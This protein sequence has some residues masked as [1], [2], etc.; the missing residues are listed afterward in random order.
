MIGASAWVDLAGLPRASFDGLFASGQDV[1]IAGAFAPGGSIR[2]VD[3]G[4]RV[5]GRW[6]FV[7]GCEHATWLY[8]N[9]VEGVENG[10]PL[11]RTAV[12]APDEVEIEDTW[13]VAGLCGP[14]AITSGR[15]CVVPAERTLRP[16]TDE[17]CLDEPIV[18][19][20]V[21]RCGAVVASVALG[22][23][24]GHWTT[25]S[26]SQ[27]IGRRS[28]RGTGGG[29]S[30]VP[31]RIGDGGHRAPGCPRGAARVGGVAV[32]DGDAGARSPCDSAPTLAQLRYGDRPAVAVVQAA[33]RSAGGTAVYRT[34]ALQR[35]LRD[36]FAVTQ[37][38]IVRPDAMATAGAVLVGHDITVPIF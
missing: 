16:L 29:R 33:Y 36:V 21:P 5:T 24:Q 3:G 25:P 1:V 37:H 6:G 35:R 20:P 32:G 34:C 11:L 26:R 30:V 18:R 31:G 17:P 13:D 27:Q 22:I 8:G 14:A 38:F 10:A 19:I 4:Y 12:F 7:S 15:R 28:C 2:A 23:A 9:A